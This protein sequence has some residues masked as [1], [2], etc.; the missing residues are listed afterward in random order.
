MEEDV[1]VFIL[2]QV[3]RRRIGVEID[4]WFCRNSETVIWRELLGRIN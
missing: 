3:N 4:I 1:S 2:H